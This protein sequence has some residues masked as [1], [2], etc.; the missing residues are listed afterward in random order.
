[1]RI[2]A[3]P[4]WHS[5]YVGTY[6]ERFFQFF[7]WTFSFIVILN[8]IQI[9]LSEQCTRSEVIKTGIACEKR[10]YLCKYIM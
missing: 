6:I 10:L 9:V 5:S 1:M 4:Y 8:D 2:K 3:K 7:S